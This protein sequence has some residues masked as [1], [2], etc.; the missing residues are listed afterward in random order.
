MAKLLSE[1][2]SETDKFGRC[3]HGARHDWQRTCFHFKSRSVAGDGRAE[4]S[5]KC[6]LVDRLHSTTYRAT[7]RTTDAEA[8]PRQGE[9]PSEKPLA[10]RFPRRLPGLDSRG[11]RRRA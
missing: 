7:R 11:P 2:V 9:S 4:Q 1:V 6:R 5:P 10:Q 8:G 3:C